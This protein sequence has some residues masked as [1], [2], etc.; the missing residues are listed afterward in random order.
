MIEENTVKWF[1]DYLES[2]EN[3]RKL[4]VR[5]GAFMIIGGTLFNL[6][7]LYAIIFLKK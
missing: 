1:A 7:M 5:L 2:P 3:R 6:F 4:T